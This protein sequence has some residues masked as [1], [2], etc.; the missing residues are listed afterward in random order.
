[1]SHLTLVEKQLT[2]NNYK[3]RAYLPAPRRQTEPWEDG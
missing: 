2:K 3:K 1:V